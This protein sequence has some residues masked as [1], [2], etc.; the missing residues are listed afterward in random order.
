[1]KRSYLNIKL[2]HQQGR[3]LMK[4]EYNEVKVFRKTLQHAA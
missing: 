3:S 2:T 4:A 1:M